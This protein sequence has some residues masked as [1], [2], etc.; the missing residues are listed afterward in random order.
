VQYQVGEAVD[1]LAASEHRRKRELE[2]PEIREVEDLLEATR[3]DGAPSRRTSCFAF[4]SLAEAVG[5]SEGEVSRGQG[6]SEDL[7]F[8]YLIDLTSPWAAP[9]T[10][11]DKV[12]QKIG[13]EQAISIAR[14]YWRVGRKWNL[15]EYFGPQMA[16][17]EIVLPV[18][19]AARDSII[20]SYHQD[21]ELA[22]QLWP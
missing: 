7:Y 1:G 16:I 18:D 17:Q 2:N 15:L 8:F 12:R 19:D 22:K 20:W 10:L 5:F 6:R 14:E 4:E 13:S 3:P 11:V 21:K 9:I